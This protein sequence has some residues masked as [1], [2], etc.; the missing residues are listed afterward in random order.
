MDRT[1]EDAWKFIK[2]EMYLTAEQALERGL[3]DNVIETTPDYIPY[4]KEQFSQRD[5]KLII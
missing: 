2:L 5:S 3:A 4:F 1:V